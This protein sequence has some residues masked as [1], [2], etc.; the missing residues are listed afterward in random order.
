VLVSSSVGVFVGV[1][2]AV[3]GTNVEVGV[4][5]AALEYAPENNNMSEKIRYN[6]FIIVSSPLYSHFIKIIQHL[7]GFQ[8]LEASQ[9]AI[10]WY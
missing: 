2:V 7:A 9:L 1:T 3:E 8:I 4:Y 6:R 10:K 5:D